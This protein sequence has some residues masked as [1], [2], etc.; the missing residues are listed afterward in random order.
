MAR[1]V[2]L[3]DIYEKKRVNVDHIVTV[4]YGMG[5]VD[6]QLVTGDT[7]SFPVMIDDKEHSGF[8]EDRLDKLMDDIEGC[9]GYAF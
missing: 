5:G 8:P 4:N 1:F 7:L 2:T 3:P 9:A 6:I